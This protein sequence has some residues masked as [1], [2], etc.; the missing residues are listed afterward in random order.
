MNKV[1]WTQTNAKTSYKVEISHKYAKISS[2]SYTTIS[3]VR[4]TYFLCH[5]VSK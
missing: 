5:T 3:V 2:S 1:A 4:I